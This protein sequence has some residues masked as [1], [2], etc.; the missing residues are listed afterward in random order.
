M[1]QNSLKNKEPDLNSSFN[2]SIYLKDNINRIELNELKQTLNSQL[3][4]EEQRKL[5]EKIQNTISQKANALEKSNIQ[6][7]ENFD[8][9]KSKLHDIEIMTSNVSFHGTS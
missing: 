7:K 8:N 9:L 3:I 4:A 1:K 5:K 6:R 2:A